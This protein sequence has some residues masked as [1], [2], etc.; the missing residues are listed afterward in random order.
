M[1][2]CM[3]DDEY[4]NFSQYI[5]V[6]EWA[7]ES[8]ET[9]SRK[10]QD[11]IEWDV[12]SLLPNM[13]VRVAGSRK[14]LVFP[15][16]CFKVA[17]ENAMLEASIEGYLESVATSYRNRN[18]LDCR[19]G[20]DM[21]LDLK[22]EKNK[23]LLCLAYPIAEANGIRLGS[24]IEFDLVARTKIRIHRC[25]TWLANLCFV[26]MC[27]YGKKDG[28]SSPAIDGSE[29]IAALLGR[30]SPFSKIAAGVFDSYGL[31]FLKKN[32]RQYSSAAITTDQKS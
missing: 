26:L 21:E 20:S 19:L 3:T 31:T 12:L 6:Q 28:R 10:S 14:D 22:V 32:S 11:A 5:S 8:D 24:R 7:K 1:T 15:R 18:I 9:L 2:D 27:E 23:T 30:K 17:M 13:F 4:K 25:P 16:S 29:L